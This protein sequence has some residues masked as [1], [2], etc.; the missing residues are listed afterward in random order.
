MNPIETGGQ[1]AKHGWINYLLVVSLVIAFMIAIHSTVMASSTLAQPLTLSRQDALAADGQCILT[2]VELHS[3]Q[4]LS[5]ID[6]NIHIMEM[7]DG[8]VGS[9]ASGY[10]HSLHEVS[11]PGQNIHI[12]EMVDGPVG[13]ATS[14]SIQSLSEVSLPDLSIHFMELVDGPVG[15]QASG[16]I[17]SLHEV[18]LPAQNTYIM[19]PVDGPQG[20]ESGASV[21]SSC[22]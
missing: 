4:E 22:Q 9:Q 11:L 1:M 8:P 2:P 10:I 5:L 6:Q 18:S 7:V 13:Y 21:L 17:H 16:Y 14:G 19:E 20:Y 15:S 12:I 3:L